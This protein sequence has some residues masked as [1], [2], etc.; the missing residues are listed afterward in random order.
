VIYLKTYLKSK[1]KLVI[2]LLLAVFAILAVVSFD[3]GYNISRSPREMQIPKGEY[4]DYIKII[5]VSIEKQE[6]VIKYQNISKYIISDLMIYVNY[7]DKNNQSI[8]M[9]TTFIEKSVP[10][11][12]IKVSKEA[13]LKTK[14]EDIKDRWNGQ[15]KAEIVFMTAKTLE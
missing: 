14:P 15:L 5:N 2:S 4:K 1:S 11:N 6:V 9:A 12:Y 7:L 10:P 13:I 3:I 8:G